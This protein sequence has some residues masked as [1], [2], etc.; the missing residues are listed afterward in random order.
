MPGVG[1]WM[2]ELRAWDVV[3][4]GNANTQNPIS[5]SKVNIAW[6]KK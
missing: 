3:L 2:F 6:S 5:L 4:K 1:L